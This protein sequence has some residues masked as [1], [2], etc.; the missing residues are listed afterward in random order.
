MR[1]IS[2]KYSGRKSWS[3]AI[4][5]YPIDAIRLDVKEVC[6]LMAFTVVPSLLG[7]GL[8]LSSSQ[9]TAQSRNAGEIRGTVTDSTGAVVPTAQVVATELSTGVAVKGVSGDAGF[10]DLPYVAAGRYSVSFTKDAFQTYVANGVDLHVETITVNAVLKI[11]VTSTSIT[12][13]STPDLLQTESPE[14]SLILPSS[15]VTQLPVVGGSWQTLLEVLPGVSPGKGGSDSGNQGASING[16][17]QY[18]SQWLLDGGNATLPASYNPDSLMP[19]LEAIAEI[20]MVTQGFGAE[21]GVGLSSFNVITKSGTNRFLGSVWEMN[22][23]DLYDAAPKNWSS[24]PQSKPPVRWNLF[25]GAIGGP[26]IRNRLFFF[27]SYQKNLSH[28]DSS[29]LYTFPTDDIR[30]G[31]FSNSLLNQIFDPATTTTAGGMTTRTPFQNNEIPSNRLDPV[32][33]AVQKYMP[34]PNAINPA[35]PYYNNYYFSGAANANLSWNNWRVDGDLGRNHHIYTAG[36]LFNQSQSYPSPDAPVDAESLTIRE[37]AG[38]I[39][40]AWMISPHQ[41]N[42]LRLAFAREGLQFA[43]ATL[44]K[45]YPTKIGLPQLPGNAF[46]V[47]ATTGGVPSLTVGNGTNAP[48]HEDNVTISDTFVWIFGKHTLKAGGEYDNWTDNGGWNNIQAGNFNFNGI[49]TRDPSG[50]ANASPGI[51]YADFLVGYTQSWSVAETVVTGGRA[52]NEQFFVQDAYKVKPN[53]TLTLGVRAI[54]QNGWNE[55]HNRIALFSPTLANP[56]TSTPGALGYAGVSIPK[57]IQSSVLFFSPR[58]G[59]AWSPLRATS[60]RGGFGLYTVPWSATSYLIGT[61]TG[62]T[63]QGAAQSADNLTDV[64][65]LSS[66]PPPPVYPTAASR[67][68][69]LLNGQNVPYIPFD[70]PMTYA[71]QWQLSVERQFGNYLAEFAYVGNATKNLP[72]ATDINQATNLQAG[73][74]PNE[75]FQQI[76]ATQFIGWGNYNALQVTGKRQMSHGLSFLVNYTWAKAFDTGTGNGGNGTSLDYWQNAYSPSANY[77]VAAGDIRDFLNGTIIYQLPFGKGHTYLNSG[78]LLDTIIGGWQS[79]SAYNYRSGLPFTPVM[80]TANLS[81]SQSGTWYPNR[82]GSGKVSNPSINEWF[83][84]SAFVEPAEHTFGN[85]GRDILYGPHFAN[86]DFSLAKSF[87]QTLRDRALIFQLKVDVTDLFNHPNYGQPDANIGTGPQ[88]GTI[89]SSFTNRSMQV[90]GVLHF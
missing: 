72:F 74:R 25:G 4:R 70:S 47:I 13:E 8:A 88:V 75:N 16:A 20:D 81:F 32:A 59:F 73:V 69:T 44:N 82:V 49:G 64:F 54:H 19:P 43:S 41:T 39:T 46:P 83:D 10:Y 3:C 7:V 15:E 79:S 84:S 37:I 1:R 60:I 27:T 90:N 76:D 65:P 57:N 18:Q 17:Q 56:A 36:E 48:L 68:S 21:S 42:E 29:G 5:G 34:E 24:A 40:D 6:S 77:G 38:Q 71:E 63:P 66:G 50:A 51:G 26:I 87:T 33:L 62:W 9:A 58:V 14:I 80:G 28:S 30:S 52:H 53:L 67:T 61:G 23:N 31:N 86:V 35:N 12:V 89:S 45:N 11:G 85:S 2:L 55:E 78:G 22:Q